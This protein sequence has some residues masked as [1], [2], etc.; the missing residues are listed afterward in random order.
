MLIKFRSLLNFSLYRS[1]PPISPHVCSRCLSHRSDSYFALNDEKFRVYGQDF[2][3]DKWTSV[4]PYIVKLLQ[5]NLIK[6]PQQPIHLVTEATK[7]F[8]RGYHDFYYDNPVVTPED[9]F[10]ALLIP[11]DHISRSKKDTYYL[12]KDFLLRTHTSAHQN[13]CLSKGETKFICIG[14]VYRRDEIDRNHYPVF[15]QC[16]AFDTFTAQDLGLPTIYKDNPSTRDESSQESYNAEATAI[17]EAKLKQQIENY[18]KFLLNFDFESRWIPAYFPFTHPSWEFEILYQGKWLEVVGSGIVEEKI[19]LNNGITG[20][21]GWALGFGLERLA[22]VR[23]KVPDV[24]LFWS[25]D[26]AYLIQFR[27]LK[28]TDNYEFKPISKFPSRAFDISFWIPDDLNWSENDFY[29]LCRS[30]GE[31]CIEIVD[32]TD[33]YVN[34]DGRRSQCFKVVYRGFDRAI[35]KSTE[36]GRASC[37]ER[38]ST[39]V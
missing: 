31:E 20:K 28:P 1:Q 33:N 8:F 12:T 2:L 9:N 19:L 5:R 34:S 22:M 30:L 39:V 14:D 35:S 4:T 18:V 15:H 25:Q 32:L 3:K 21:I 13:H 36:I 26:P 11:K 16:E 10:D 29:D 23:Y 37:R 38:V 27:D 24:R 7:N 6:T 17:V